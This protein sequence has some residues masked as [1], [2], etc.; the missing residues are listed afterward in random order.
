MRDHDALLAAL[1]ARATTPFDWR[2]NDCVRYAAA[3][4]KAQ[5]GRNPLRGI[6]RWYSAAGARRVLDSL[7]GMEAA[8]SARLTPI[9]PAAAKRGDIA[10][11]PDDA[12]GLRLMVVEGETLVGPCGRGERREPRRAMTRAWSADR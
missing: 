10:G 7:G 2:R 3:A 12:L 4:V 5:T 1:S 6:K 9:A 11:V 8:V